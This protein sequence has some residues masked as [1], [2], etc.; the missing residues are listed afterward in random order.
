MCTKEVMSDFDRKHE[1]KRYG[2]WLAVALTL[3][4][5]L[6]MNRVSASFLFDRDGIRNAA[7]LMSGFL[8]PNFSGDFLRRVVH[9][10]FE[11][12]LVGVL[13]TVF[14]VILGTVVALVA[15]RVPDLPDSPVT[16]GTWLLRLGGFVRWMARFFLGCL[17]AIPEIV[18]AYAFVSLLGLGPGAAVLAIAL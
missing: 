10:S 14:A 6:R 9:L 4:F 3:A 2:V 17:R 18:W 5:C 8:K 12:L 16:T 13:G 11:S 7:A 15:I 1:L